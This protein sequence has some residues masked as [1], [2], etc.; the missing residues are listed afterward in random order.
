MPQNWGTDCAARLRTK[1]SREVRLR[2]HPGNWQRVEGDMRAGL[3]RDLE[4]AW[5]CV[6]WASSAGLHA[7]LAG[8]PVFRE[9]PH[10]VAAPAS[11]TDL[12]AIDSPRRPERLSAFER[13]A[14]H[15]WSV[16]ELSSGE[17]FRL[18]MAL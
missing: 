13:L 8:V 14:W 6:I 2:P 18:L 7:L 4:G 15:Q 12:G 16:A 5:A 9:A 1:T 10:W 3:A 11:E 17:P